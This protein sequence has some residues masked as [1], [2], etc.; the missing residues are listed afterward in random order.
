MFVFHSQNL[1]SQ[2]DVCREWGGQGLLKDV[3]SNVLVMS[4]AYV[5][6]AGAFCE[7]CWVAR[8]AAWVS[9]PPCC[10]LAR[11]ATLLFERLMPVELHVLQ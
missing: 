10:R 6:T 1:T 2:Y 3:Y 4:L 11:R 7:W 9:S 5:I 8:N